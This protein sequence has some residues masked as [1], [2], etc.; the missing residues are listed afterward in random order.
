MQG[1]VTF[2]FLLYT[3]VFWVFLKIEISQ[4]IPMGKQDTNFITLGLSIY[5]GDLYLTS[6]LRLF[7]EFDSCQLWA[8]LCLCPVHI[9]EALTPQNVAVYLERGSLQR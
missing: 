6:I 5:R 2:I 1:L 8:E 4:N 3:F 7:L 9:F